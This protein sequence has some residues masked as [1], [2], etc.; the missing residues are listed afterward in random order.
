MATGLAGED[1]AGVAAIGVH[2]RTL[3]QWLS[4]NNPF[5]VLSA[6]L[7]CLGLWV[8]FGG[9]SEASQ[10][11]AL[12]GGLAGYTLLLAVT[13]C[14]LVRWLGVWDDV[15]TVMLLTV[16]MFLATSVT[17]D[18]VL[19][20]APARG[21]SCYL[22][23]LAFAA[24]VSEGM[25]RGTRLPLARA[26]RIP[27]YL[28]LALFYL[29][30]LA[31][32]PLLDGPRGEALSWALFGF[33]P[34]AGL[35]ALTL[36]PAIRRGRDHGR[37]KGSGC[38]WRWAWYPW[39][40]FGVLGFAVLAR[41]PLLCWSMDHPESAAAEPFIFAPYFLIPFLLA[42]A[43][44]LLEIGLVERKGDVLAIALAVPVALAVL[45]A[46]G[47]RDEPVYRLFL[48]QFSSRSGGTPFFLTLAAS[49]IFYAYAWTRRVAGSRQ[50]LWATI[51]CLVFVGPETPDPSR[52]TMPQP[53]PLSLAGGMLFAAGILG[54]GPA[55]LFSGASAMAVAWLIDVPP[56]ESVS[57]LRLLVVYH[58]L[59]F[60]ILAAGGAYREDLGRW[61][62]TAGTALALMACLIAACSL[63]AGFRP[64][65]R[66]VWMSW[67]YLP[68]MGAFLLVYGKS[69]GHGP[70]TRG[71]QVVLTCCGLAAA[72]RGYAPL[73]GRVKG[74]DYLL[75]GMT[76]FALAWLMS[77]AKGGVITLPW[78][79]GE[80]AG[81][82]RHPAAEVAGEDG[83]G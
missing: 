68:T 47:H 9:S 44:L 15:R 74:L 60:G 42:V 77:L 8:S 56:G 18:E 58:A 63:A 25:L 79:R 28:I 73:R 26:F 14:L 62:R 38:P 67:T 40:L 22:G 41:I 32:M 12:M 21:I 29:Y 64:D 19:V 10:A 27:Y 78:H 71:G 3:L 46:V 31:L 52:L 16:L 49:A 24:I 83:P 70:S 45:A 75:L 1:R 59:T 50:L 30:P 7:V 54:R 2:S 20:E 76:F 43:I 81:M 72:W 23:G 37:P 33:S 6:L 13:A 69:L 55:R 48:S 11:W 4:C 36:I 66:P 51:L 61:L 80:P 34:A 5:Y 35:V 65:V 82:G 57:G 39:T 53:V 17:F